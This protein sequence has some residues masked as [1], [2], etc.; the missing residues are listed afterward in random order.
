MGPT[1]E[2]WTGL[3]APE[4]QATLLLRLVQLFVDVS[5]T[6]GRVRGQGTGVGTDSVLSKSAGY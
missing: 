6:E 2:G 4:L 1:S 5:T 3:E